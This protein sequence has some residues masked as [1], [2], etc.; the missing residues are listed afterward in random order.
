MVISEAWGLVGSR[1][2]E[3]A[4]RIAAAL[5]ALRPMVSLEVKELQQNLAG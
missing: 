1:A 4:D 5:G 3:S 2:E